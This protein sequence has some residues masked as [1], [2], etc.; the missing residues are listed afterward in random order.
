MQWKYA[1]MWKAGAKIRPGSRNEN[2]LTLDPKRYSEKIV[3]PG[4]A[5]NIAPSS[6]W[7]KMPRSQSARSCTKELFTYAETKRYKKYRLPEDAWRSKKYERPRTR[8]LDPPS[9]F[10]YQELI[11]THALER[12]SAMLDA[13]CSATRALAPLH[14]ALRYSFHVAIFANNFQSWTK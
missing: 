4:H 2:S 5:K 7:W 14:S 9:C 13:T 10:Y 12:R 8:E 1:K 3:H 6:E 11:S